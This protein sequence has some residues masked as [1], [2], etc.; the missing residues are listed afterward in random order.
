MTGNR[1]RPFVGRAAG[2]AMSAPV[3]ERNVALTGDRLQEQAADD[4]PP[5][6]AIRA[7]YPVRILIWINGNPIILGIDQ[8]SWDSA[9][10]K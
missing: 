6:A 7:W 8:A 5:G 4:Q 9:V 1:A 2:R 10:L 3:M